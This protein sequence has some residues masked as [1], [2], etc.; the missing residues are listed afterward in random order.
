MANE[1]VF[2]FI[3]SSFQV[4][5]HHQMH[6][7]HKYASQNT[8]DICFYG[9]E[10]S[11]FESKHTIFKD[12]LYRRSYNAFLFFSIRQFFSLE[13]FSWDS[14]KSLFFPDIKYHFANE[15]ICVSSFEEFVEYTPLLY[16]E[17]FSALK[18]DAYFGSRSLE[19]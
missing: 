3:D 16:Q 12:Y 6:I 14:L 9:A 7:I 1:Q 17:S 2:V 15:S 8:L 18:L 11:G 13:Y 5:Q 10:V 19:L 4:S